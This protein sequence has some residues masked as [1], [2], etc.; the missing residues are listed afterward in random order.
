MLGSY[1]TTD[2]G[3]SQQGRTSCTGGFIQALQPGANDGAV[4]AVQRNHVGDRSQGDHVQRQCGIEP[5]G[6]RTL[7]QR[8]QQLVGNTAGG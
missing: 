3:D 4:F 2:S 6:K 7:L 8:H 5:P 1:G